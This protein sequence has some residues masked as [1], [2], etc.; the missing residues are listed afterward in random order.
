MKFILGIDAAWTSG[1]PSGVALIKQHEG[2]LQV[3]CVAPS[4]GAFIDAGR[5]IS[6]NWQSQ[7]FAGSEP[8]ISE[9]LQAAQSLGAVQVDLIALDI[10]L[11]RSEI[12]SRRP[13]DSA[14]SKAF[15][16]KGCSTH[17]PNGSR[18]GPISNALFNQL[19]DTGFALETTDSASKMEPRAIEVYPHPAL[20]ALLNRDYRIPY[21]V[22]NSGK[23]WKGESARQRIGR[24]IGEFANIHQSLSQELGILPF[25]LPL[26]ENVTSFSF[27]KRYED[28]IDALVCAW[29][30][31]QHLLGRTRPYGDQNSAIW[32]PE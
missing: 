11:A 26:S 30:G 17:S 1:Q 16:G 2:Q 22:G 25:D 18:P 28:A 20:L 7:K 32:V 5:G 8:N 15:G 21:K 12:T 10:P 23:Y 31:K 3:L 24:L 27:L 13:S 14:I 9:L 4:Y 29:V 6:V 19:R